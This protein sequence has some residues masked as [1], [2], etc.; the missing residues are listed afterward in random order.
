LVNAKR[1]LSTPEGHFVLNAGHSSN[2][3]WYG[4]Q[5]H[6]INASPFFIIAQRSKGARHFHTVV[7]LVVIIHVSEFN[8]TLLLIAK[9]NV[10]LKSGPGRIG[11]WVVVPV[12][13]RSPCLRS[14]GPVQKCKV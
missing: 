7:G 11:G 10:D 4:C 14:A 1:P 6:C 8:T 3:A 2:S 5:I 13:P 12:R 9:K